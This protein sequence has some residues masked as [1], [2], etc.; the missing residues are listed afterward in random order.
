MP[1]IKKDTKKVALLLLVIALL[2]VLAGWLIDPIWYQGAI[3][4]G[5]LAMFTWFYDRFISV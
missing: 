3:L 5:A 1:T 4:F 2:F